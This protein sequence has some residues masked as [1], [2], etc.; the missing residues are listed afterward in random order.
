M[1]PG[2]GLNY[3][4]VLGV[5]EIR[6]K[7]D[8]PSVEPHNKIRVASK[9]TLHI[10]K[11]IGIEG[12]TRGT[13]EQRRGYFLVLGVYATWMPSQIDIVEVSLALYKSSLA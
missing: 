12:I 6:N 11:R 9:S 7:L 3:I 10:L 13:V 1:H 2:L 5:E 4:Q 8:K